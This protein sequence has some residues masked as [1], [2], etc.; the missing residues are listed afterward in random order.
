MNNM[1]LKETLTRELEQAGASPSEFSIND[2]KDYRVNFAA[3]PD[4]TYKVWFQNDGSEYDPKIY[5]SLGEAIYE[6]ATRLVS[7]EAADQMARQFQDPDL[8][9]YPH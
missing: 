3:M 1:N 5:D 8:V 6:F 7:T 2:T 4:G 9:V